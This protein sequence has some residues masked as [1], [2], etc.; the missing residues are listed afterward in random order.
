MFLQFKTQ[1]IQSWLSRTA[2]QKRGIQ[3]GLGFEAW[4]KEH[5]GTNRQFP[6]LP[7]LMLH[8]FS[9]MLI[10]AVALECGY[11]A[12]SIR[13]RIYALPSIGYGVLLYTGI[14][15]PGKVEEPAKPNEAGQ[16]AEKKPPPEK[17]GQPEKRQP[18][19]R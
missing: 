4:C 6:G 2:V 9:H 19:R 8:S 5:Q 16:V 13:E 18:T 11:P 1:A 12:S 10:T 7:Y 3:L 14:P 15:R 17:K